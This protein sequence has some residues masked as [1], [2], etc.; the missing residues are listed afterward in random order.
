MGT[1][2]N[3]TPPPDEL[4]DYVYYE[5]GHIYRTDT[6]ARVGCLN[7]NGY[8]CY[9]YQGRTYLIHRLIYWLHT[10]EWPEV[11]DHKSRIKTDNRFENLQAA[12]QSENACNNT[13]RKN[14]ST[15]Y[16]GVEQRP[17]GKYSVS[18]IIEGKRYYIYGYESLEAAALARDILIRLFYGDFARYG[19][20]EN[21]ALKVGGIMI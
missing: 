15:G 4:R 7:R 8:F 13:L 16:T 10:G 12:T 17:G 5:D 9:T 20:A 19:I 1:R 14:S 6:K 2:Y 18:I 11:V 21:A 3:P